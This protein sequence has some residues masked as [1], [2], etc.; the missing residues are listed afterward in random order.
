[1]ERPC[2]SRQCGL[3]FGSRRSI[4]QVNVHGYA[5]HW[6]SK[7]WLH[8]RLPSLNSTRS[9]CLRDYDSAPS[10]ARLYEFVMRVAFRRFCRLSGLNMLRDLTTTWGV[11]RGIVKI[12]GHGNHG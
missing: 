9:R 3:I 11:I 7:G 12:D 6:G 4:G 1:L 8:V 5:E 10:G 2:R